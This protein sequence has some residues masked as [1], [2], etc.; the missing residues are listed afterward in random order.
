MTESI[1]APRRKPIRKALIIAAV[2]GPL[3]TAINQWEAI[4]GNGTLSI[5]KMLLTFVVP[6]CVSIVSTYDFGR[7]D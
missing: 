3:L 7:R 1:P 2:V 6:F 5:W 4:F